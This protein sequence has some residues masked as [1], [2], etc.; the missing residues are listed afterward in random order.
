MS[1]QAGLVSAALA[2]LICTTPA[3]HAKPSIESATGSPAESPTAAADEISAE[4]SELDSKLESTE[5][6]SSA[7]STSPKSIKESTRESTKSPESTQAST[8]SS[9]PSKSSKS[10]PSKIFVG[11]GG[12]IALQDHI[13][14]D[15]RAFSDLHPA[16]SLAIRGGYQYSVFAFLPVRLYL[17]YTIGIRPVGLE[18]TM[19]SNF[20]INADVGYYHRVLDDLRLGGFLGLGLGYSTYGKEVK[21]DPSASDSVQAKGFATF[22]NASL[23]AEIA[24]VHRLEFMLKLPLI[25]QNLVPA[26]AYQELHLLFIYDYLF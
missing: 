1:R 21:E 5:S 10:S 14:A 26:L 8:E 12:G 22:F 23:G 7:E 17:D 20:L 24:D 6:I 11:V 15:S 3:L 25:K 2:L 9:E 16:F 19:T 4:S 18:S 13:S